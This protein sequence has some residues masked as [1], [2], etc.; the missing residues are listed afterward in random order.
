M[1]YACLVV[2][3]NPSAHVQTVQPQGLCWMACYPCRLL[4]KLNYELDYAD[5]QVS[6]VAGIC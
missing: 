6:C 1:H 2:Q 5:V 4:R 3:C